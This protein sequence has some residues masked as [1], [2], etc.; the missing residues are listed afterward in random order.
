[1]KTENP[2][3]CVIMKCK[4][5]RSVVALELPVAQSCVNEVSISPIIQSKPRLIKSSLHVTIRIK[6]LVF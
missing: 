2:N 4:G 1:V 6:R 5:C 3:A